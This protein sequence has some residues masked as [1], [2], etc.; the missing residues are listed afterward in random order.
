MNIMPAHRTLINSTTELDTFL[1][2]EELES[3]VIYFNN[4]TTT[5]AMFRALT[6]LY[7]DKLYSLKYIFF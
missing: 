2:D 4:K 7:K 1:E 6:S 5:P 3:K